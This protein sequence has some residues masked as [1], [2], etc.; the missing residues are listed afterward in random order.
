MNAKEQY[1]KA[2]QL[3]RI[4]DHIREIW[5]MD[6]EFGSN[7]SIKA[8][9]WLEAQYNSTK[10]ELGLIDWEIQHGARKSLNRCQMKDKYDRPA[11]Y[12]KFRH[13]ENEIPF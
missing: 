12:A 5:I 6:E 2:Y 1:T 7:M 8:Y 11:L 9:G 3:L 4:L 13:D 10:L